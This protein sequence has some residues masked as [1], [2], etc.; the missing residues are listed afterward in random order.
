M[1]LGTQ[2]H[3]AGLLDI[4]VEQQLHDLSP[5]VR[6]YDLWVYHQSGPGSNPGMIIY[7]V[8][9]SLGSSEISSTMLL[10][11]YVTQWIGH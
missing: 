3:E 2:P 8:W 6:S 10:R 1:L 4:C 9:I 7:D 5:D 11:L